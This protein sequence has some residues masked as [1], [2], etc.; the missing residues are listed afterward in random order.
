LTKGW[1]S[2]EVNARLGHKPSSSEIDKYINF[3]AIDRH[4]PKK[5]V[6][7]FELSKLK[8]ELEEM[9]QKEKL[10]SQRTDFLQEKLEAQEKMIKNIQEK[11]LKKIQEQILK[12]IE[13]RLK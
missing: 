11:Q 6:Q 12:K 8:E 13:K 4:R 2:D 5:K 7:E 10:R 3:L 9:K 1:T